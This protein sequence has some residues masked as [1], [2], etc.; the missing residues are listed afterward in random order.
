MPKSQKIA[1]A[2][3]TGGVGNHIVEGLLEL[4]S[5]S[6]TSITKV[7]VLSRSST[8]KGSYIQSPSSPDLHAPIISVDYTSVSSISNVLSE[9]Q[10]D[11]VIS[12]LVGEPSQFIP[13]QETLLQAALSVPTVHR[14]APSEFGSD[15]EQI[16][17]APLYKMKLPILKS[18]REVKVRRSSSLLPFEF[19]KFV[20]G[21]FMNHLGFGNPKPNGSQALGHLRSFPYIVDI[22]NGTA[23]VPG[24]GN[25]KIWYTT[26]EDVGR[27]VAEATQ[28]DEWPEESTMVGDVVTTN[29]VIEMVE[30]ISGELCIAVFRTHIPP[31]PPIFCAH[32]R[33]IDDVFL[34]I[35]FSG[36]KITPRYNT[37]AQLFARMDPNP[38][39]WTGNHYLESFL[40]IVR[41]ERVQKTSVLNELTSVKPMTVEDYLQKWW[42]KDD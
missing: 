16:E 29:Q 26:A 19:T 17:S 23:D 15:S 4:Q 20:C 8:T 12:T 3:G 41:G 42:G 7:I 37:E 10:I 5:R 9:H 31:F 27:F 1:V 18:L 21:I 35:A 33:V 30:R 36:K 40:S 2:G 11:T 22:S 39:S 38:T 24:D 28:L 32:I 13:A 6:P 34:F 25:D 14:F